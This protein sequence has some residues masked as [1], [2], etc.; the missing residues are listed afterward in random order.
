MAIIMINSISQSLVNHPYNAF[1]APVQK[2][3]N[4]EVIPSH[5][6]SSQSSTYLAMQAETKTRSENE[7]HSTMSIDALKDK[8]PAA[9]QDS[10]DQKSAE[11]QAQQQNIWQFG[12]QQHYINTQK[13]ALNAYVVSA[14]GESIDDENDSLIH[15]IA[16]ESLSNKYLALVEQTLKF[17]YGDAL[18]PLHPDHPHKPNNGVHIQGEPQTIAG[19]ANQQKINQYNDVQQQ[20]RSSV[21]H[22]SA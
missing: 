14:T 13:A 15:T 5:Q 3:V 7:F 20:R 12:V 6:T 11:L 8:I 22:L 1:V 18:D 4:T 2:I 10:I 17:N 16:N 19:L 21:L 9:T